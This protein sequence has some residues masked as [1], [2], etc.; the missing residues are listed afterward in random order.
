MPQGKYDW[1]ALRREYETTAISYR[2]LAKLRNIPESTLWRRIQ[3][4]RWIQNRKLVRKSAREIEAKLQRQISAKLQNEL[5]PWI[6]KE[7][8]K[9]TRTGVQIAKTGIARVKR[10]WKQMPNPEPKAE[11]FIAK[12]GESWHRVGRIALGMNDGTAPV[13]P[14]SLAILG[15]HTAVQINAGPSPDLPGESQDRDDSQR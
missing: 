11:A 3:L 8:A 2:K 1:L 5:A 15:S 13:A 9:F 12:T 4:E 7:K 6:E 10:M 14:L